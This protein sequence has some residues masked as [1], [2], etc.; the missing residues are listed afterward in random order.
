M[1]SLTFDRRKMALASLAGALAPALAWGAE[2]APENVQS[3]V[4]R[5]CALA[6]AE[7]KGVLVVFYSS[8]CAW[9]R[10]MD[11]LLADPAS[12]SAIGSRFRILHMRVLETEPRYLRQQ[13]AGAD[14]FYHQNAGDID[15]VPFLVF[16]D[17]QGEALATTRTASGDNIGFP[18]TAAEYAGFDAMLARAAPDMT[19]QE[20]NDVLTAARRL[21]K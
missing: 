20:R 15:G 6:G 1:S 14:D 9:C 11:A 3:V 12:V 5:E 4:V 8:W 2:T 21:L 19:A 16:L 7:R 18:G 10:V 17:A 13:F